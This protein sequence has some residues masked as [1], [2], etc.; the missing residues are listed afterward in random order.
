MNLRSQAVMEDGFLSTLPARGA[1]KLKKPRGSWPPYFYPR[2]PRGERPHRSRLR[3]CRGYFYPRSPRGERQKEKGD[4]ARLVISIH[5]PREGS[6]GRHC[7]NGQRIRYF[8]P[9]SPRGERPA[10]AS[11]ISSAPPFLSTLPARGA[12]F[13]R[14]DKG[15]LREYISIHAPREGSD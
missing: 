7:A 13:S 12:T 11:E 4:L 8:Y 6:D 10:A 2:S 9:R 15:P 3:R 1:T 5:A 14:P